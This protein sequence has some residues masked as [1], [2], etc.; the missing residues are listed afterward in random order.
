VKYPH[1]SEAMLDDKVAAI[2]ESGADTIT[3]CDMGCLM[4]IGGAISRRQLPVRVRHIAQMLD[5]GAQ[6]NDG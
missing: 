4:H 6:P 1:I 2:V 3:A 5:S